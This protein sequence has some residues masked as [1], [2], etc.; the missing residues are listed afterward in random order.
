MTSRLPTEKVR[1]PARAEFSTG[2]PEVRQQA[3]TKNARQRAPKI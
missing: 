2:T 3:L 1:T